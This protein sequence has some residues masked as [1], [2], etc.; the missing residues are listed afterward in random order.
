MVRSIFGTVNTIRQ[1]DIIDL[2][3]NLIELLPKRGEGFLHAVRVGDSDSGKYLQ[4][5]RLNQARLAPAKHFIVHF[6]QQ[7][8]RQTRLAQNFLAFFKHLAVDHFDQD[9]PD[10]FDQALQSLQVFRFTL[11]YA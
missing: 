2:N 7:K 3:S 1:S 10:Y 8:K 4:K 5:E 11:A 6:D 9:F